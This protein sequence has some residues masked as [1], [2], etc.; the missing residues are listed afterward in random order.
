MP[1]EWAK[2]L[3]ARSVTLPGGV[4][5]GPGALAG[6]A[7]FGQ[8][9]SA[10]A[11]GIGRLDPTS[12]KLTT[13]WSYSRGVSGMGGIQADRP[14]LVWEQ[15]DS[16]TNLADWSIHAWNLTTR[17]GSVLATSRLGDGS[18][19]RGQQPLP[20]V[21]NGVAAWAQPVPSPAGYVEAQIRVV[22]LST[23]RQWTVD[24]GRVSSPVYAGP[25][26]IW[27]KINR[28]GHYLFRAV[29]A[30]SLKPVVLPRPLQHPGSMGYLAGSP[31][32]L[33]W[34]TQDLTALTVWPA[35]SARSREF[36][37]S[38]PR[39]RFQFLQL[40][41]HF[42][43]WYNG[44]SSSV[45]DLRTGNGFDVQG[46]VTGSAAAIT[47]AEPVTNPKTKSTFVASRVST[48]AMTAAPGISRC[49]QHGATARSEL[50]PP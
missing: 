31:T 12:G 29:D 46:T 41:G 28:S 45:L 18:Y 40:A 11:S 30:R 36:T 16:Q 33:A 37:A 6:G 13:I 32:Y 35:G 14:W 34:S 20:V 26:L 2:A 23:H 4:A 7:A 1:G 9:N 17:T 27:G 43:L 39:H 42:V 10:T 15:L 3:H 44:A 47:I 24:T 5:F 8:F 21:K 48:I 49:A 25:Y 19:V 50:A 38:G 22:N